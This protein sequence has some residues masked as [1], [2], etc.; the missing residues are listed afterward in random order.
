MKIHN[1]N[2]RM[3]RIPDLREGMVVEPGFLHQEQVTIENTPE[4][5]G[6]QPSEHSPLYRIIGKLDDGT[7]IS[8]YSYTGD[9][10]WVFP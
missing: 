5:V 4:V 9:A 10:V 8:Q 2:S 6:G 1:E 7:V 3:V